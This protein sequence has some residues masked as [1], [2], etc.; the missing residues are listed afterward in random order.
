MNKPHNVL[1]ISASGR[2]IDS[3]SRLLSRDLANALR[4]RHGILELAHR[5]LAD[6]LPFVDAKWIEATFTAEEDRDSGHRDALAFSDNLVAEL[7]AADTIIIGTPMY[8]F[9]IPAVLKAWVD[10]I[11]RARLTFH[12]TENGP[13]GLLKGKKAYIVVATGGVPV[14]S[15]MDFAT[16]YLKQA[17]AFVGI[18]DVEIIAAD[19]LNSKAEE[20]IDSARAKI[21][22]LVHSSAGGVAA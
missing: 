21:A 1:E 20:S 7:Q 19:Q 2:K 4:Q 22:E 16:P 14:G 9:G 15:P 3:V 13:E 8:N 6:G 10:L 12:Y 17:L 18:D 11:A 5:D